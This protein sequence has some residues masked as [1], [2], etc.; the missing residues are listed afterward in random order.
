MRMRQPAADE[1]LACTWSSALWGMLMGPMRV[2]WALCSARLASKIT[3]T[4]ALNDVHIAL[5]PLQPW[6]TL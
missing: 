6:K 5:S 1:A 3:L 2:C 4:T